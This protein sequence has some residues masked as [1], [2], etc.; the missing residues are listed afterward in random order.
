MSWLNTK[1][2]STPATLR[3]VNVEK[4]AEFAI[5]ATKRIQRFD[6][7]GSLR[8][9]TADSCSQRQHSRFTGLQRLLSG[10]LCFG[11]DAGAGVNDIIV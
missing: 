10:I 6:D 11:G 9:A 7:A 2:S 3:Q 5:H 4:R 8:P 1:F